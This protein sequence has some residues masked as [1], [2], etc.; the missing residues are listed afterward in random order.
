M[1]ESCESKR[2][3]F[4]AP[5]DPGFT[6]KCLEN[7]WIAGRVDVAGTVSLLGRLGWLS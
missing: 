5:C 2:I 4:S 3:I 7:V 1:L 6:G